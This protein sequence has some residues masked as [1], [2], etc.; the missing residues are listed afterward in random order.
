MDFYKSL[1]GKEETQ[2]VSLSNSFW[3]ESEKVSSVEKDFLE[4]PFSEE[5]MKNAVFGSYA[6]GAPGPDGF[7]FLFYQ[8]FWE[9][10]KGDLMRLVN[11]FW[12]NNLDLDRLNY[13]IITLIPKEPDAKTLEKFRPI[14]LINCSLNVL[15]N[16]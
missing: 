8:T 16:C 12:E 13:A 4:A 6:D 9:V 1:F 3:E 2:G 11:S 10:I 7:R 15:R 5:E 14:N